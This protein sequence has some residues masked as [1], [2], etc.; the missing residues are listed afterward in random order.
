MHSGITFK[1]INKNEFMSRKGLYIISTKS[2]A[3]KHLYKVGY[4]GS[5]LKNRINQIREVLSPP[6]EEDIIIYGLVIPKTKAKAGKVM[7]V[8]A[9]ELKQIEF[10]IHEAYKEWKQLIK[11]VDTKK[12]SE[13][14]YENNLNFLF[15]ILQD[16][17]DNEHETYKIHF[18]LVKF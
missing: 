11:F 15:E 1:E 5:S 12:Y 7:N 10:D 6:L 18:K 9:K 16:I 14:I 8:R 4:S 3:E 17:L 13:W 2:L